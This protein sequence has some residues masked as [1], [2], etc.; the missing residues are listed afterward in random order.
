MLGTRTLGSYIATRFLMAILTTF[1]LCSVLIYLI[2][3]VELL[4]QSGKQGEVPLP[5]LALIAILRLPA[6]AHNAAL[7]KGPVSLSRMRVCRL[8]GPQQRM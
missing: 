5:S 1:L 3:F 7:I 2:D 6:Y 4:R 8:Y